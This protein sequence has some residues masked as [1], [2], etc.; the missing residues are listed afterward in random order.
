MGWDGTD[1]VGK[2]VWHRAGWGWV[3]YVVGEVPVDYYICWVD[4]LYVWK[5]LKLISVA[6]CSYTTGMFS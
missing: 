1:L 4:H 5:I 2:G 3:P 6:G